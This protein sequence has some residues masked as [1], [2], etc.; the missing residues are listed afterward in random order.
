VSGYVELLSQGVDEPDLAA[1]MLAR[2]RREL[3]RIQHIIGDL[4][5]YAR[6]EELAFSAVEVEGLLNEAQARVRIMPQFQAIQVRVEVEETL[7][8]LWIQREKVHQVLLNLLLNAADALGGRGVVRLQ[9]LLH[10]DGVL[11]KCVDSGPGF[12]PD[13]LEKIFEPFFTTKQPGEGTG[14][15]L[16]ISHRIVSS[17]GG[18]LS[19]VNAVGGGAELWV[20]LPVEAG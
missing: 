10:E 20:T 12:D 19:A 11:L 9:A 7:P 13:V 4:L 1:D 8:C 5:S 2:S 6:P 18:R 14:L 16:A 17:Q 3:E 15:G